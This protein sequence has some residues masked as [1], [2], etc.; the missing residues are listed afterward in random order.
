LQYTN[1]ET[2]NEAAAEML[3]RLIVL[4]LWSMKFIWTRI[5]KAAV[6]YTDFQNVLCI[7]PR[8]HGVSYLFKAVRKMD[9]VLEKFSRNLGHLDGC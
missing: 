2:R 9:F 5:E 3:K 1:I 6:D 4:S 8:L 7:S